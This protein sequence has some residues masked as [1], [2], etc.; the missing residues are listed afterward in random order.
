M[1][2]YTTNFFFPYSWILSHVLIKIPWV[3]SRNKIINLTTFIPNTSEYI[4]H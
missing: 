1:S 2:K 4:A 3:Q